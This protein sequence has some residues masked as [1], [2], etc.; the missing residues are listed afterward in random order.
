MMNQNLSAAATEIEIDL[1][2]LW[3]AFRRRWKVGFFILLASFFLSAIFASQQKPKYIATGKLLFKIDQT[4]ALTGIGEDINSLAALERDANPINTEI[5]VLQSIP[6]AEETIDDLKKLDLISSFISAQELV[7]QLNIEPVIGTDVLEVSYISDNEQEARNIV[8][9][10]MKTYLSSNLLNSRKPVIVAQQIVDEQLPKAR[11]RV[12][13]REKAL[14]EFKEKYQI[15]SFEEESISTIKNNNNLENQINNIQVQLQEARSKSEKIQNQLGLNPQQAIALQNII[16]SPN[17]PEALEN[18]SEL[19]NKILQRQDIFQAENPNMISLYEQVESVENFLENQIKKVPSS[20]SKQITIADLHNS[21]RSTIKEELISNLSSLEQTISG[22]EKKIAHLQSIQH[23]DQQE[24][25]RIPEIE[26]EY[27]DLKLQLEAAQSNYR[28][29]LK[30]RENITLAEQQNFNNARIIESAQIVSDNSQLIIIMALGIAMGTIM[31]I[32]TMTSLEITDKSVKNLGKL[33]QIFNYPILGTIPNFDK[34]SHLSP[35][36]KLMEQFTRAHNS[37]TINDLTRV[38]SLFNNFD[39]CQTFPLN[40]QPAPIVSLEEGTIVKSSPNIIDPLL[41]SKSFSMLQA[42]F[43]IISDK[44]SAK[45]IVISSSTAQEGKSE[46]TANFARTLAKLGQKVLVIDANLHHPSQQKIWQITHD[47][48][49]TDIISDGK[50]LD[51]LRHRVAD[52]L[53][54]LLSG[55]KTDDPLDIINSQKMESLIKD[56]SQDYDLI[57]IDSPPVI[58]HLETLNLG[59]IADGILLVARLGVLDN[60]KANECQNLLEMTEQNVIGMVVN[61][62]EQ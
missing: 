51:L 7:G 2:N 28:H 15:I 62:V 49:L 5:E 6:I 27:N 50:M 43:K 21:I 40:N 48:G 10:L 31:S 23:G 4:S 18:L 53:D 32:V 39:D 25:N 9:Q 45:T 26:N 11:R 46:V 22:L 12:A 54:L 24:L 37:I 19:Q 13:Q 57:L 16:Q 36:K 30:S 42:R 61:A 55:K 60:P 34:I 52:N 59:K 8:N 41:S 58:D 3:Y 17:V 29:L 38:S 47:E 56:L 35:L 1:Y 14:Q 33:Q 44:R 20:A